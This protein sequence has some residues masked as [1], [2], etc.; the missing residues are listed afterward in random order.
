M[1][2]SCGQLRSLSTLPRALSTTLN[3]LSA[4]SG[5]ACAANWYA[6]Q[7]ALFPSSNPAALRTPPVRLVTSTP[8]KVL[9][10]PRLPPMLRNL[11]CLNVSYSLGWAR[12]RKSL[13]DIFYVR[14]EVQHL[15]GLAGSRELS[16]GM[17]GR[18]CTGTVISRYL[19]VILS[20]FDLPSCRGSFL[21]LDLPRTSPVSR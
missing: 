19:S 6:R 14:E 7:A 15:Q 16:R 11:G 21:G 2:F 20:L 18:V 13:G 5:L 3:T 12:A 10:L 4:T 1:F 17:R 9:V 8:V